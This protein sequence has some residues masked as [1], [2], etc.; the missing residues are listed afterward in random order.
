MLRPWLTIVAPDSRI[1]GSVHDVVGWDAARI[2]GGE[3]DVSCQSLLL[4][5]APPPSAPDLI[6]LGYAH[7]RKVIR[8][9]GV[10]SFLGFAVVYGYGGI[11]G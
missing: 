5:G 9:E 4:S 8:S 2:D 10:C 6:W 1:V 3:D 11:G 7:H